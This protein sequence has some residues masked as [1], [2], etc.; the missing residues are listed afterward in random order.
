MPRISSKYQKWIKAARIAGLVILCL[1]LFRWFEHSQV[2]LPTRALETAPEKGSY[3]DFFLSVDGKRVHC[4]FFP[5]RDITPR[6][7]GRNELAFLMCHGNGGNISHRLEYVEV[8]QS[9]G[10]STLLFDYRGF[11]QSEGKP[12]EEESYRDAQS[13]YHWLVN[14]KKFQPQ[15]IFAFGESLGGGVASELAIRE[16]LG[17]LI[18]QSTFTS[19]PDV[20][21]EIFPWLPVRLLSTIGYKTNDK[22]PRIGVPVLVMH[23]PADTFIGFHHAEK[24]FAAARDPKLFWKIEGDHNDPISSAPER[25]KEGLETFLSKYCFKR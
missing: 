7:T 18:L 23:S 15:N 2:Y 1:M 6:N 3:E 9:V 10:V 22:L 25:F 24:N 20:G 19:I 12:G 4:W 21:A 5:A 11:G 13:A 16:K 17:G 8:F 14:E